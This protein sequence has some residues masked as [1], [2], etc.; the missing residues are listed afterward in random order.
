MVNR[1]R[2]FSLLVCFLWI[3]GSAAYGAVG[4]ASYLNEGVGA[5]WLGMGGA[6]RAAARD[7]TA[8]CW[9]PAGLAMQGP[10][11]WQAGTMLGFA[12]H[13]RSF[14]YLSGSWQTDR[15]GTFAAS[16]IRYSVPGLERVDSAG[17]VGGT[18]T[19]LE[20]ALILSLGKSLI[21]QVSAGASVKI[22]RQELFDFKAYGSAVD[23]GLVIQ[24][25]LGREIH[26]AF[27]VENAVSRFKWETGTS[28]TL[29]RAF[30]GGLAV[31]TPAE[32]ALFAL[33]VVSRENKEDP[34]LHFGAEYW[35]FTEL[36]LR[37]GL[38]DSRPTGGVTYFWKPYEFDYSFLWNEDDL[39]SAHQFSFLLH[40]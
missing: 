35:A 28:D 39:G 36:A 7:V 37:A 27:T 2:N 3:C 34:E 10:V 26:L 14:G 5:R 13:G 21:Y 19:N 16:W 29:S 33:D 6:A 30:C 15:H 11:E 23:L 8:A 31:K 9:N 18:V 1:E 17:V 32:K 22:L 25:F 40:F 38:S 24:P 4:A 20:D 12:D